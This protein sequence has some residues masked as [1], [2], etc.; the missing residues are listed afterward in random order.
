M[1]KGAL[2]MR[3]SGVLQGVDKARMRRHDLIDEPIHRVRI[4]AHQIQIY[5]PGAPDARSLLDECSTP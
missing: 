2:V 5:L 3:G 4:A 1:L